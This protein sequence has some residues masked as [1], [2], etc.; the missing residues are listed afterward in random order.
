MRNWTL[1][2]KT[3]RAEWRGRGCNKDVT[4][5]HVIEMEEM[6]FSERTGPEENRY[7]KIQI[8]LNEASIK[9]DPIYGLDVAINF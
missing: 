5:K 3:A 9:V 7:L 8:L 2:L 1:E 4:K 6:P